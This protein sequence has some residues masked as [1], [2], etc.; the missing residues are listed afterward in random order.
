MKAALQE[1]V[2]NKA[3]RASASFGFG[4]E[5]RLCLQSRCTEET[6]YVWPAL[7]ELVRV[8]G[9][10]SAGSVGTQGDKALH[11]RSD[12]LHED[13]IRQAALQKAQSYRDHVQ[14]PEGLAAGCDPLR[15]IPTLGFYRNNGHTQSIQTATG[16]IHG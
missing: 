16:L 11:P 5:T 12:A 6:G 2:L 4:T 9:T 14:S 1:P 10:K 13:G 3:L 15:Q 7:L 8:R